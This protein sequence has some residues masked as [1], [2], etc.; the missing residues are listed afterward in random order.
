MDFALALGFKMWYNLPECKQKY[1]QVSKKRFLN[2]EGF[3]SN[4]QDSGAGVFKR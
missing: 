4:L 1:K 3:Y 2:E